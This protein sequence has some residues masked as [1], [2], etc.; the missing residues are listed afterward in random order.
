MTQRQWS[1]RSL[2]KWEACRP[3]G[4]DSTDWWGVPFPELAFGCAL[5]YSI[6]P[7]GLG[8]IRDSRPS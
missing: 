6:A 2:A 1:K 8:E 4:R 5:G 7:S 3:A